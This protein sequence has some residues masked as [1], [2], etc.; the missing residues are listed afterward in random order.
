MKILFHPPKRRKFFHC[1][2]LKRT[3][4]IY[5]KDRRIHRKI[6]KRNADWGVTRLTQLLT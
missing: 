6:K 5:G 3:L 2:I 4:D 1:C